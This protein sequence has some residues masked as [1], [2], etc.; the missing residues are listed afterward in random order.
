MNRNKRN[1]RSYDKK[2]K[3]RDRRNSDIQRPN[4]KM[5]STKMKKEED[6]DALDPKGSANDPNWYFE[7]AML[8]DQVSQLSFQNLAGHPLQVGAQE[9]SVPNLVRIFLNPSPGVVKSAD[10]TSVSLN[11][12]SGVNL[13]GFRIFSKLSAYTGRVANYGPQD[14]STMILAMGE[15]ISMTEWIRRIFGIGYAMSMRNRDYPRHAVHWGCLT[16]EDDLFK[17]YSTYRT[18]FNSL[19]TMI[20]QLPIPKG[21]KYFEKCASLYEKVFLDDDSSMAQSLITIPFSTWILDE[22]S[23]QGGTIL[24][25]VQVNNSYDPNTMA[26]IVPKKMSDHLDMLDSLISAMLNSSTLQVVYTDLLNLAT[27]VGQEFWKLDYLPDGYIVVPEYN[28]ELL[29]QIHN[30]TIVGEPIETTLQTSPHVTP[31]NDVYPNPNTNTLYY[32]PGFW[33]LYKR[34][35]GEPSTGNFVLVDMT[36]DH[37]D[38]VDRVE[39]TRYCSIAGTTYYGTGNK[40]CDAVLPDHY[41]VSVSFSRNAA[42]PLPGA[43]EWACTTCLYDKEY[44]EIVSAASVVDWFPRFYE[45]D[46]TTHAFTGRCAGDLNFY[47]IVEPAYLNKLHQFMTLGL[48]NLRHQKTEVRK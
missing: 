28:E 43:L 36:S 9:F 21:I 15:I 48:Y 19:I 22:T 18:R 12:T 17:N 33:T 47:T 6:I 46:E 29:L 44:R 3:S 14:I 45:M 32:N 8:A 10:Y 20:N 24:K 38:V 4:N 7:D 13:A 35:N 39:C 37:P 30:A 41:V 23:Y 5:R 1:A 2:S 25:T 27:K 42:V 31:L 40:L 11:K 16:D 34:A 26:D